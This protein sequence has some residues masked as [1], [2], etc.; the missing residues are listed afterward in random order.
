MLGNQILWGY[1]FNRWK[2]ITLYNEIGLIE[3]WIE[4]DRFADRLN[5]YRLRN[6]FIQPFCDL[7]QLFQG[8]FANDL[9]N[10][11]NRQCSDLADL[12]P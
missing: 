5:P 6:N 4:F 1:Q 12:D 2:I 9:T 10:P 3:Q 8:C 11:L 7:V